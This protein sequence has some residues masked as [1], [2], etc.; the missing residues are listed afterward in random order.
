MS[1]T[2][3]HFKSSIIAVIF[4]FVIIFA[5][6]SLVNSAFAQKAVYNNTA[7]ERIQMVGQVHKEGDI[8]VNAVVATPKPAV[9]AKARS[10]SEIY[11]TSCGTCHAAGVAG[12]PKYGDKA[13]WAA[14]LSQGID[15]LLNVAISGKGAMP[16]RGTC[17]NCSDDE[18]KSAINYML[19][20]IK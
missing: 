11:N 3:M 20:S 5:I 12:A 7:L 16:P 13:A 8:D 17:G 19:D 14:R 1:D 10:G 15:G 18:L 2:S 9:N 4:I 6:G